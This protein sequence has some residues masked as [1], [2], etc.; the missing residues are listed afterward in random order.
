MKR[1]VVV[2]DAILDR[3]VIGGVSRLCPDAPVPVVDQQSTVDRPGGAGLAAVLARRHGVD[4]AL[5]APIAADEAGAVL[6]RSLDEAGVDVVE[7]VD[8]GSTV[9]KI[10]I[11]VDGQSLLRLDRGAAGP[12]GAIPSTVAATLADADAILVADYGQ[13][14]VRGAAVRALIGS[15]IE[16]GTPVVWDPHPRGSEPCPG[17]TLVTPNRSEAAHFD[18]GQSVPVAGELAS[19][20]SQALRL[21]TCWGARAVAVT[22][23][24]DGAVVIGADDTPLVVPV[25][26]PRADGD[27]CGAGDAF[28]AACAAAFAHGA[29]VGE[30][31]QSGVVAAADFVRRGAASGMWTDRIDA[32]F[33]DRPADHDGP[34]PVVVA[35]GGCFDVLHPGHVA[36]LQHARSLGDRLVVL[37]NG[38]ES[39][40][41]LKGPGRPVQR[42]EDRAAVLASLGCVD[43][44]IVFDDDTP[45]EALRSVRPDVFVKGGDYTGM[46]LPE[47]SV[48][49]QWGGVVV[50]VPF[51]AGRSTTSI[52]RRAASDDGIARSDTSLNRPQPVH[53]LVEPF[54]EPFTGR[55]P[56]TLILLV[57]RR[58]SPAARPVSARRS[59]RHCS[60]AAPTSCR[61][62]AN[63]RTR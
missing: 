18:T 62:T 38:D 41:R 1:I 5:V 3:D 17:A 55:Y 44:V 4:V 27:T 25:P 43:E 11:R 6:R 31:V 28:A 14:T 10:R 29:V 35:A 56:C 21:R 46:V 16:R 37:I 2:G 54:I 51:M 45:V 61:S 23:G 47:S 40:R 52:L 7:L 24:S 8:H 30:A 13:Q 63:R 49:A 34:R 36:T 22:V 59:R 33:A 15:A 20:T 9:E 26:G 12:V 32:D 19:L 58:S 50:T 48:M 60:S 53:Q 42:A 57:G 39:V